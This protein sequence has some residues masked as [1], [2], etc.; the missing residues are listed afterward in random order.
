MVPPLEASP[1][2]GPA[3]PGLA[4][5]PDEARSIL[6]PQ[7]DEAYGF[8]FALSPYRGCSHACRYCY[9]REYPHA[10]HPPSAWGT[11]VAPKLNAAEL[12]WA[13]RHRLHQQSVFMSTGTDPYQPLEKTCRLTRACL[14]VLLLCATTKVLVHTR[15][16]LVLRD[17]D[18]LKAFGPRLTVGLSIP[19]DDDTI[20]QVVEPKAP[21]IPTRWATAEGLAKAGIAVHVA[22]TPLLPMADPHAFG[23]RARNCGVEK[24]WVGR[25]RLLK[26]DPMG[27]VLATHG[28]LRALDPD[29]A[30]EIRDILKAYVPQARAHG[31]P[32]ATLGEAEGPRRLLPSHPPLLFE[33][34]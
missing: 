15:S 4:V 12:L 20:R 10:Q 34:A 25:L 11:W 30:D 23:R 9:L 14:E 2:F 18:L 21:P 6:R 29:Y 1:D 19:T 26:D 16:S 3:L 33:G 24:L 17:L 7:R 8:G 5:E 31:R 13:S 27:D 32:K 22:A 28:W